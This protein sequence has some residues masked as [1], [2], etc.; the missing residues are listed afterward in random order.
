MKIGF[1]G[2]I[3]GCADAV[4]SYSPQAEQLEFATIREIF[5]AL[6][7]G[8]I[9]RG[10][11]PLES[12][13]HGTVAQTLD[14]LL[15][16]A[17]RVQIVDAFLKDQDKVRYIVLGLEASEPSGI[18][19]TT[20]AVYPR[21]DRVGILSSLTRLIS[22]E[23]GLNM[24]SIQSRPDGKG[25][26]IFF[27]DIE[28][29][30]EEPRVKRCI[31]TIG[32]QIVDTD[33][34]ILGSYPY[35]SFNEPLI[36]TLGLIGG[37]GEMGRWFIPFF[38][39]LG[40]EVLVA[41]RNSELSYEECVRQSDAVL[42][43]VPIMHTPEVISRIA[44][45]LKPG[46]LLIDNTGVKS[47]MIDAM[48]EQCD[49]GVEILSIHTMFGPAIHDL[50]R[51]NIICIPTIRSRAKSKEFENILHKY[52][53]TITSTTAEEHDKLVTIT[54]GLEHVTS[55][56]RLATIRELVGDPTML[57]PYS[58]PNSRISNLRDGRI[59]AGKFDLYATMLKENKLSL[60][61]L[62][63]YRAIIDQ[64]IAGIEEGRPE[65]LDEIMQANLSALPPETI[66]RS[67]RVS[68]EI[69]DLIKDLS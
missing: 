8:Q 18:D 10:F 55:A 57:R 33:V 65:I 15:R 37:S 21:R 6:V 23:A 34:I 47:Q 24:N 14:N 56:A 48:L 3:K 44:P 53:A 69:Q 12:M 7:D 30:I 49:P 50:Q 40:Y 16:Y 58:T 43:N 42:I 9:E 20:L 68:E 52:G 59:H 32:E 39:R 17:S 11:L 62:K 31:D 63:I 1:P 25:Q 45:I 54:Q 35:L 60:P 27:I 46:Q 29:H 61:T 4:L 22:L 5:E 13:E 66:Q 38:K 26:F 19:V 67:V 41:G 64:I 36:K 51:E 2:T 28:G